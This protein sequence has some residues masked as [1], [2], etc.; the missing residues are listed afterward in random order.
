[1][2]RRFASVQRRYPV[3]T[4]CV[5]GGGVVGVGD[6]AVQALWRGG[7]DVQRNAVVS[8][9]SGAM[10]PVF[11]RW[12]C[13]LERAW[14]GSAA[15]VVL[16]K[17]VTNQIFATPLNMALFLVWAAAAEQWLSRLAQTS[18]ERRLD[19]A[20]ESAGVWAR[21]VRDLPNMVLV[22]STFWL[23]ANAITFMF[24]PQ[25]LRVLWVSSCTA[26]WGGLL[27]LSAHR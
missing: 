27:G 22:A 12:W 19:P 8:A 11:E 14:P 1:M 9:Y 10:S 6:A 4:S 2:Y 18:V 21:A 26:A 24:V 5:V 25:N 7:V 15:G 13:A 23:P 3:S 20:E 16:R 17:A